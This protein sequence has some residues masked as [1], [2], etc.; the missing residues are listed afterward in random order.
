[1]SLQM[2]LSELTTQHIT[3][4]LWVLKGNPQAQTL[5]EEYSSCPTKSRIAPDDPDWDAKVRKSLKAEFNK[6]RSL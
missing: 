1:M 2:D 4:L 5:Y 3:D 6:L